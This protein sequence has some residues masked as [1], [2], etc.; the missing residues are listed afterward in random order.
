MNKFKSTARLIYGEELQSFEGSWQSYGRNPRVRSTG[1]K[2]EYLKKQRTAAKFS[3]DVQ[4][5]AAAWLEDDGELGERW[6]SFERWR[7][8][9]KKA[10]GEKR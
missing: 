8:R 9:K 7:R 4:V 3:G 1:K 6:R 5:D 2:K 10:E